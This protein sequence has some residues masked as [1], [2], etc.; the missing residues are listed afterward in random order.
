[1]S[2]SWRCNHAITPGR[3]GIRAQHLPK[4]HGLCEG[5]RAT[6]SLHPEVQ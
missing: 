6:M 1:M 5:G 4:A 3:S 2:Y